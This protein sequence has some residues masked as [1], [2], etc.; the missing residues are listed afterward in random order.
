MPCGVREAGSELLDVLLAGCSKKNEKKKVNLLYFQHVPISSTDGIRTYVLATLGQRWQHMYGPAQV[1]FLN[2]QTFQTTFLYTTRKVNSLVMTR[3]YFYNGR[4]T[5]GNNHHCCGL[6]QMCLTLCRYPGREHVDVLYKHK[7]LTLARNRLFWS[8]NACE[9][10][11]EE[12]DSP[13]INDFCRVFGTKN[14]GVQ[15]LL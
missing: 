8:T 2:S 5:D 10:L 15:R 6:L 11:P 7:Q 13:S 4:I 1:L 12:S 14:L 3:P 9:S